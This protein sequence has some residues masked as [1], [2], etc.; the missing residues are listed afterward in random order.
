MAAQHPEVARDLS[1]RLDEHMAG[2]APRTTGSMQ[3][4]ARTG[5]QMTFDGLPRIQR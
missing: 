4:I 2:L 1:R 5:G 3:G